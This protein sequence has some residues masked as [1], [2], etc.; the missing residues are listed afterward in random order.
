MPTFFTHVVR[1]MKWVVIFYLLV[2]LILSSQI[3]KWTL[4]SLFPNEY[5]EV[6]TLFAN[7]DSYEK[8]KGKLEG[9]L[10]GS[11]FDR[12]VAEFSIPLKSLV[13]GILFIDNFALDL[14]LLYYFDDS[15]LFDKAKYVKEVKGFTDYL[16]IVQHEILTW[17]TLYNLKTFLFHHSVLSRLSLLQKEYLKG[18]HARVDTQIFKKYNF[19]SQIEIIPLVKLMD[20]LFLAR[21]FTL[22]SA[23]GSAKIFKGSEPYFYQAIRLD[24]SHSPAFDR[25]KMEIVLSSNLNTYL[26][27][28][29]DNINLESAIRL[30]SLKDQYSFVLED[31]ADL[32]NLFVKSAA[33]GCISMVPKLSAN[34]TLVVYGFFHQIASLNL[35]MASHRKRILSVPLTSQINAKAIEMLSFRINFAHSIGD[36]LIKTGFLNEKIVESLIY[37][38]DNLLDRLESLRIEKPPRRTI[39]T[40]PGYPR[41]SFL[42]SFAGLPFSCEFDFQTEQLLD[43]TLFEMVSFYNEAPFKEFD[44]I[45]PL[46]NI[47]LEKIFFSSTNENLLKYKKLISSQFSIILLIIKAFDYP[48]LQFSSVLEKWEILAVLISQ[49]P[50]HK[51][52]IVEHVQME[53]DILLPT[54]AKGFM[55]GFNVLCLINEGKFGS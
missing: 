54:M 8:I 53:M 55:S 4:Y 52:L 26:A 10:K 28:I 17:R 40:R 29:P 24:H 31:Y 9:S 20:S 2:K 38:L 51:T 14:G 48:I 11:G 36:L 18:L 30:F 34:N 41:S 6:S 21:S 37:E 49:L 3:N 45:W 44:R 43:F 32:L 13:E 1:S 33:F 5:Q 46:I 47:K 39:K 25:E 7:N 27:R 23:E 22:E 19:N 15:N 42:E 16:G 50:C 12:K 35:E